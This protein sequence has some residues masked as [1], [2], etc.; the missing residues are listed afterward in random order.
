M[1]DDD[2]QVDCA[3]YSDDLE[4]VDQDPAAEMRQVLRS[5]GMQGLEASC[6]QCF[7][8]QQ[9]LVGCTGMLSLDAQHHCCSMH[10]S[11]WSAHIVLSREHPMQALHAVAL[12]AR[13]R[14]ICKCEACMWY[15]DY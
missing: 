15:V 6:P 8:N 1:P 14:Q 3:F 13:Q 7:A 4:E 10:V 11:M 12:P 2:V 9:K 5:H